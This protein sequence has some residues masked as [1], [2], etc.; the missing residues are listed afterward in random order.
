[1]EGGEEGRWWAPW[2]VLAITKPPNALCHHTRGLCCTGVLQACCGGVVRLFECGRARHS[3]PHRREL[4]SGSAGSWREHYCHVRNNR[5]RMRRRCAYDSCA[6]ICS[7][8]GSKARLT[9]S[10]PVA[11]ATSRGFTTAS[12][13]VIKSHRHAGRAD[14]IQHPADFERGRQRLWP[15]RHP[16]A[17]EPRHRKSTT[18][19]PALWLPSD[20]V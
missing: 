14:R 13:L 4:R 7:A 10:S 8:P 2:F 18:V 5:H 17:F 12:R 1:L 3:S 6:H 11:R 9:K 16:P 20:R 19:T 15:E